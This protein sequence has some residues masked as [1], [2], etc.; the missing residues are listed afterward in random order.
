MD[1][2]LVLGDVSTLDPVT[3][4]SEDALEQLQNPPNIPLVIQ[5]PGICHSISTYLA[6]EHSSQDAYEQV[7]HSTAQKFPEAPG[8]FHNT[9][10]LI[11][12]FTGV[13]PIH[14]CMCPNTCLA[15]TCHL[16][17]LDVCPMCG[18][19]WWNEQKLQGSNS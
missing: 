2:I 5:S 11:H 4:L 13:E 1:F 15:Y 16:H 7:C 10:K 3:K 14:H 6:L 12:T 17:E 9:K 19:L 8:N 18:T